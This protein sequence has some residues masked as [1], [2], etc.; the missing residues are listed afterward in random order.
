VPQA[1]QVFFKNRGGKKNEEKNIIQLN[2]AL[3]KLESDNLNY[4]ER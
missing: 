1:P 4:Q 3:I 2:Q